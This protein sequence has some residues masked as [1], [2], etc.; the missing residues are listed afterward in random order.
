MM[1]WAPSISQPWPF[2]IWTGVVFLL[3]T[4]LR[5]RARL[6]Q[7]QNEGD[8]SMRADLLGRIEKLEAHLET[9]RADRDRERAIRDA[10]RAVDRHRINNLQACF[11]AFVMLIESDP[12]KAAEAVTRIK[13]MRAGQM[14]LE[15]Q[16]K[17]A[18]HV[19]AIRGATTT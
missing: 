16:E 7:L 12:A 10:E 19:G 2:V 17:A 3:G 8:G 13:E 1:G 18:I 4:V 9:E 14:R 11:D 5:G 15:A 6:K